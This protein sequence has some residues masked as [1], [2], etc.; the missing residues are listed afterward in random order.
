M[1]RNVFSRLR[2]KKRLEF[3]YKLDFLEWFIKNEWLRK[4]W[5]GFC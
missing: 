2:V 4:H 3:E 5:K 1:F